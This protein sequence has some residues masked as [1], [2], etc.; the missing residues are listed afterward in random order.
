MISRLLENVAADLV[1]VHLTSD[2]NHRNG[3]H[4]GGRDGGDE[5]QRAG[6]AGG[7]SNGRLSG[8]PR[9]AAGSVAAVD[10]VA[11]EDMPDIGLV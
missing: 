8:Y 9:V 4:I 3:V 5:V 7:D 6:T 10:L 11:D 2:N 1:G